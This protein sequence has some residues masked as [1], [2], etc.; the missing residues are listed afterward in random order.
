MVYK[1]IRE[2][3][4][5]IGNPTNYGVKSRLANGKVEVIQEL[6]ER[7]AKSYFAKELRRDDTVMVTYML[8]GKDY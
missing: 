3:K 2:I 6:T 8:K 4:M 1:L 7:Q 5:S